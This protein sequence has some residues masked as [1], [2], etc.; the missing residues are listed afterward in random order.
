MALSKTLPQCTSGFPSGMKTCRASVARFP[1]NCTLDDRIA[2]NFEPQRNSGGTTRQQGLR[3]GRTAIDRR[4][5]DFGATL[6]RKLFG[7]LKC[8][9][10]WQAVR[11]RQLS[12]CK[13]FAKWQMRR[14]LVAL[15]AAYVIA[16]TAFI[17]PFGAARAAVTAL[18]GSGLVTC[19][20]EDAGQQ[21]PAGDRQNDA[22]CDNSCCIGCLMLAAV[23]PPPPATAVAIVQ[24]SGRAF[25]TQASI[26]LIGRPEAKFQRQRAPPQ[27]A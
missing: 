16:L 8:F 10:Y 22:L 14:R 18:A 13:R 7:S 12:V 9:L 27:N 11:V 19:H 20:G 26:S 6:V 21:V 4:S 24:S 23:V 25:G 5:C 3:T 1:P 15:A 17:G 2:A